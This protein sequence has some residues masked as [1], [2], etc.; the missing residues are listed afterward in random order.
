MRKITFLHDG[1]IL[2]IHHSRPETLF[3]FADRW[4]YVMKA[5]EERKD[6]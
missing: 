1:D 5:P 6:A 4:L 2:C 3:D